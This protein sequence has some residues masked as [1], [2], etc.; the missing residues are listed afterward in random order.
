MKINETKKYEEAHV[1]LERGVDYQE[2]QLQPD[3]I[4]GG[5]A[6]FIG[7]EALTVIAIRAGYDGWKWQG[8]EN[9]EHEI[10]VIFRRAV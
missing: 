2:D 8:Y 1:M 9:A 5:R 10:P 7:S 4:I 3:L 6:A